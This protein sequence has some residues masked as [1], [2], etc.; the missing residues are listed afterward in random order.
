MAEIFS[1]FSMGDLRSMGVPITLDVDRNLIFNMS[2]IEK[3]VDRFGS[4]DD[5]LNAANLSTVKWLATLMV[6]E[7][8]KIW[9]ESHPDQQK[10]LLDE[11]KLSR[12]VIGIQGVNELQKKVQEAMLIGLPEDQV[13]EVKDVE[14]NLM[15]A[16]GMNGKT[17]QLLK[18]FLKK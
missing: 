17:N 1:A 14:K 11:E 13:K 7:D 4:M 12:Y 15:A 6:N 18:R 8:A 5:I 3:C 16:R 2:V 9:N 10:P